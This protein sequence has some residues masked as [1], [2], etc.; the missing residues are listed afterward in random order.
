MKFTLESGRERLSHVNR[1][2]AKRDLGRGARLFVARMSDT[3]KPQRRRRSSN[4]EHHNNQRYESAPRWV[5]ARRRVGHG[6]QFRYRIS[7][8]YL[9]DMA[10]PSVSLSRRPV[11][12]RSAQVALA[13]ILLLVIAGR[14]LD[15]GSLPAVETFV[16]IFTS[17][18]V[19]ALPFVLL[20]A[21]VSALIAVYVSDRTFSRLAALPVPLQLPGAALGGLAFPVCECGSV[22]VARRLIARGLHPSAGLAFMLAAPI[23]NPIVLL[24]TVVAYRGRGVAAQMVLGR[25]GLGLV[26][27]IVAGWAIGSQGA[28]RL[29]RARSDEVDA[30]GDHDHQAGTA[31]RAARRRSF[32]EHLA[33]D[34]FFMGRFI[35]IGGALAAALQTIIPQDIVSNV[36]STPLIGALALMGIAFVLSLCSE[37]DAFVAVSF[38]QFPLGSQLAF[39]VFGPVVDAKLAFLYGATF[40][41]RFVLRLIVIAVPVVLAGSLWFEAFIR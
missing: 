38:T 36:A 6:A 29:L 17:I 10:S 14:A 7:P 19:E 39:L 33:G 13:A 24:S 22:P 26:L 3:K 23:V 20:G 37:A 35:V 4:Q 1:K 5:G 15:V 41:R 30:D 27:A 28:G 31:R 12:A 11:S 34:F 8:R 40:K 16:L 18:V 25:A 32:V 2:R 21:G 9:F